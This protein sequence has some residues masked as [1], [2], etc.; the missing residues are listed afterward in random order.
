MGGSSCK[1]KI[2]LNGG[3]IQ[4]EL[5]RL[6]PLVDKY[7]IDD[8]VGY[9]MVEMLNEAEDL[10]IKAKRCWLE[11]QGFSGPFPKSMGGKGTY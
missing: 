8:A 10:V 7:D 9:K 2:I 3:T 4:D 1:L 5:N 11:S 6:M